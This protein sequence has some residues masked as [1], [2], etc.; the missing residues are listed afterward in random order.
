MTR[1]ARAVV[2]PILQ[3]RLDAGGLCA[4]ILVLAAHVVLAQLTAAAAELGEP[5]RAVVRK[6]VQV[7]EPGVIGV[8]VIRRHRIKLTYKVW[9]RCGGS[10]TF[11]TCN[12][13]NQNQEQI[14]LH[15]LPVQTFH[16][17]DDLGI[18]K[19]LNVGTYLK[20]PAN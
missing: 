6:V 7:H 2:H 19:R 5:Q 9:V 14:S 8:R 13:C 15:L 10:H 17:K 11:P 16:Y 18:E 4:V 12:H 20:F 1:A 3:L